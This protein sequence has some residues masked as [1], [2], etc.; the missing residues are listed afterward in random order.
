MLTDQAPWRGARP[1]AYLRLTARKITKPLD[2]GLGRYASSWGW[3]L[4]A[5]EEEQMPSAPASFTCCDRCANLTTAGLLQ[6]AGQASAF[7]KDATRRR[8]LKAAV[9]RPQSSPDLA[10]TSQAPVDGTSAADRSDI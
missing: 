1:G 4:A 3:V 7:G 5:Q 2:G 6:T 9:F 10:D 8:L